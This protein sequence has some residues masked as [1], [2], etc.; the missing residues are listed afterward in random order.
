MS[1]EQKVLEESLNTLLKE[2]TYNK[3]ELK[4][5]DDQLLKKLTESSGNLLDDVELVEILNNTKTQAKEM[6]IKL[7]DANTKT[8]E[9]N[10][11]REIYRPVA[12]RGSVIYF[13]IIEISQVNWMYNSSLNQFLGLYNYSIE[14]SPKAALS[15]KRVENITKDLT[16]NVYRYVNRGLFEK[17]KV[18][19]QLMVSFKILITDKKLTGNDI[20]VFL[21][22]GATTEKS[23]VK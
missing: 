4:L 3:K 8:K 19:F 15:Q 17:D 20:S 6:S 16:Y 23:G 10:E 12:I 14:T 7:V 18:V 1:K 22:A 13:C 2:V 21:K 9:I 11:K 5:L